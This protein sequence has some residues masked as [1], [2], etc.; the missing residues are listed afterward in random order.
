[1]P[2][3]PKGMPKTGGRQKGTPNKSTE[4]AKIL[5]MEIMSGNVNKF[6]EALDHLYKEDKIKWLDVVNKFF[7]YYLPKKTDITSD[8]EQIKPEV[9]ISVVNDKIADEIKQIIDGKTDK[10][11]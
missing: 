3:K 8:G 2:G 11:H 5:F 7:P 10:D 1:M 4:Q 6:K 9:N